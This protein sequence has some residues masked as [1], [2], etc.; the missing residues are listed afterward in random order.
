MHGYNIHTQGNMASANTQGEGE[1][2]LAWLCTQQ[3]VGAHIRQPLPKVLETE[4]TSC[5]NTNLPAKEGRWLDTLA[6]DANCWDTH[7]GTQVSLLQA[8][9]QVAQLITT[10]MVLPTPCWPANPPSYIG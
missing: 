7:Q 10:A 6:L 8:S 2:N 9:S 5:N 1:M 3:W 4:H